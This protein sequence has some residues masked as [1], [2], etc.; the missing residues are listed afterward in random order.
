MAIATNFLMFRN[1]LELILKKKKTL[2]APLT[3][4]YQFIDLQSF[5]QEFAPSLLQKN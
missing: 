2:L 4:S 5:Y 3:I 1:F